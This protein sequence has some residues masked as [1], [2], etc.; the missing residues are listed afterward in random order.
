MKKPCCSSC[1]YFKKL[2]KRMGKCLNNPKEVKDLKN[3]LNRNVY[4][5][6]RKYMICDDFKQKIE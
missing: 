1:E 2:T 3:N 6:V 4:P 5:F